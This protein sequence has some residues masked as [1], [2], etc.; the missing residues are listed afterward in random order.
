MTGTIGPGEILAVRQGLYWHVGIHEGAGTVLSRRP[1]KGV[2]RETLR[3]FVGE[4]ELHIVPIDRPSF[5]PAEIVARAA[6]RLNESGYDWLE[7]NCE[8][9]VGECVYGKASSRQL[10]VA[11]ALAGVLAL[12]GK[13]AAATNVVA[14]LGLGIAGVAA[15]ALL[16]KPPTAIPFVD[17]DGAADLVV[18]T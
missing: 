2:V 15:F 1:G 18:R 12:G 5:P 7:R 14:V 17:A 10:W 4:S 16:S 9:F 8:H 6:S 3:E 11:G 13:Y